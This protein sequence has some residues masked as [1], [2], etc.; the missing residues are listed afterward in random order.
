MV[1]TVAHVSI[2]IVFIMSRPLALASG[3]HIA[4]CHIRSKWPPTN[5]KKNYFQKM[6][7]RMVN[8]RW[9]DVRY[10]V[11]YILLTIFGAI[12]L[13]G[14]SNLISVLLKNIGA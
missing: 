1:L 9:M 7:H 5:N 4:H 10:N 13:S 11:M 12:L 6:V 2:K 3:V 8:N 14:K